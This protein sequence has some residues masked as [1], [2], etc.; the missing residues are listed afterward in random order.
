VKNGLEIVPVRWIDKVLEIAL[1]R[2]PTPLPEDELVVAVSAAQV[3]VPAA[4]LSGSV[5]H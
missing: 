2:M 1:E 5:K 4:E 3:V